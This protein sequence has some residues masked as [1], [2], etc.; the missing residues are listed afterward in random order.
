M[1]CI[2]T[3]LKHKRGTDGNEPI[4]HQRVILDQE[5]K[6]QTTSAEEET[7]YEDIVY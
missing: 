2:E 3:R 4:F 1:I 5:M 6:T 7:A